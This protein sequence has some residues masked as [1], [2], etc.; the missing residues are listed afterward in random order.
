MSPERSRARGPSCVRAGDC[1]P[2]P[3]SRAQP[4]RWTQPSRASIWA[5]EFR[6]SLRS[7][8]RA[9]EKCWACHGSHQAGCTVFK[10][11]VLSTQHGTQ[12]Y[13]ST[14]FARPGHSHLSLGVGGQSGLSLPKQLPQISSALQV[15]CRLRVD[16]TPG[17][18]G[19]RQTRPESCSGYN[20]IALAGPGVPIS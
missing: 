1:G 2:R 4:A 5:T 9:R 7:L 20:A 8:L 3:H 16:R 14:S 19:R 12:E 10:L 18:R 11:S 6:Q 13:S 17:A 15:E